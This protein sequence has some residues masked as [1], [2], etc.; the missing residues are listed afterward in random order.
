M[1]P[2]DS[3][4]AAVNM[5]QK[6]GCR[7]L[8]AT[9]HSLG[10]LLDG[11]IVELPELRVEDP[12]PLAYAYP[13]LG[14]E[15]DNSPF[16]PYPKAEGRPLKDEMLCYLH[17]PGSTGFPKPIPITNPTAVHW[18]MMRA[19]LC[20]FTTSLYLTPDQHPYKNMSISPTTLQ[21]V[22]LLSP[23]ST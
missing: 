2:W 19:C 9:R 14:K 13:K 1:S 11:I 17:S 7:R 16:V 6:S 18:C 23:H 5:L 4:A 12:P 22:L 8:I 15:T 10:P 20:V 3:S 21:L